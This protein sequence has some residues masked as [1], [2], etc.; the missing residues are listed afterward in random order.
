[1]IYNKLYGIDTRIENYIEK[2]DLDLEDKFKKLDKISEYNQIKVLKSFSDNNL[3]AIHFN[4]ATG[5]G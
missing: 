5:Y 4:S 3:S 2:I 1:M